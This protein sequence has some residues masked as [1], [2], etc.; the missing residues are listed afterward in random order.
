MNCQTLF[1]QKKKKK[2]KKNNNNKIKKGKMKNTV[3]L[4]SA[5]FTQRVLKVNI[6]TFQEVIYTCRC[7]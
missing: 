6:L 1:S 7:F 3:N 2:K 4:S 5:E